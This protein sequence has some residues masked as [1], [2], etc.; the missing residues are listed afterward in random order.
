[1][2]SLPPLTALIAIVSI[3]S[4]FAEFRRFDGPINA[5]SNY[6][7]FSEGFVV[8]PGYVD[9]SDLIFTTADNGRPIEYIPEE[10]SGGGD[11]DDDG[12]GVAMEEV[13]D[14][15][16]DDATGGNRFLDGSYGGSERSSVSFSTL[17]IHLTTY[18]LLSIHK[19]FLLVISSVI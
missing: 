6:I 2:K 8:T 17:G 4:S 3:S 15:S 16:G 19:Q 1:M 9:I 13:D 5:A 7:H 18:L 10:R 12:E 14:Y 11:D